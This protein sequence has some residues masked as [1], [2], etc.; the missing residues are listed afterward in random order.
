MGEAL[1]R[2]Y[3]PKSLDEVIGQEH[4]T[5]TLKN[6]LKSGRISHA[7]LLTGPK[8]VGKTSVARILAH[9][10]S[11]LPYT[12][13]NHLDIIE[14]DAASNRRIDEIRDLRDRVHVAPTS[15]KYKVY[16]IDEVHMLTK[17]AFNA[18]LKTLEE[19]PKHVIFILA[20]TEA[21]KLPETIISR[22]QRF[23]FK[24]ID[25]QMTTHLSEL[26]QKE[27]TKVTKPALELIASHSDGSMRDAISML[28]QLSTRGKEIEVSDVESMLGI[29]PQDTIS[30]LAQMLMTG[31]PSTLLAFLNQLEE[32]GISSIQIAHQLADYLRAQLLK[33]T[34]DGHDILQLLEELLTVANAANPDK[35]LELILLRQVLD[36]DV[37]VITKQQV[38]PKTTQAV[39]V[40]D[41]AP[42]KPKPSKETEQQTDTPKP[43]ESDSHMPLKEITSDAQWARILKAVKQRHNTLYGVVRMAQPK[44]EDN[45]LILCFAFPFHQKRMNEAKNRQ[46]IQEVIAETTGS[47]VEISCVVAAG[48]K[49]DTDVAETQQTVPNSATLDTITDIFGGGEILES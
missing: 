48:T 39:E 10:V 13:E 34:G 22:T 15:A 7:Y 19:P 43:S 37:A 40:V 25:L 9:E 46:L 5:S 24:P 3:R 41:G 26:A 45:T 33:S 23:T 28:D 42:E 12:D 2:K 1:Y 20:T 32:Q 47:S 36:N 21:H 6:A 27:D 11:G 14:I 44:V 4:V 30:Q 29:A 35:R 31:T 8:G 16:I 38:A 49:P 18:L 17:E